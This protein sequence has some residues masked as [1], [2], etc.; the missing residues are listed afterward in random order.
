MDGTR[1]LGWLAGAGEREAVDWD[2]VY[3]QE[4]PRV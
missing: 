4:L 3:A 2:T 1:L